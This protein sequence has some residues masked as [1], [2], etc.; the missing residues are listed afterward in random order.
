MVKKWLEGIIKYLQKLFIIK[1][2]SDMK[3][4][5]DNG[6]GEDTKGKCSPDKQLREYLYT[7]EIAEA[8]VNKLNKLG[9]EAERIV[10]EMNDVSLKERVNRVNKVCDSIGKDKVVFVSI[11]CN[12][13]SN[14]EWAKARGWSAYT[15]KGQTKS[16]ILAD[17]LY[18]E[19]EKQFVGQKI[20][21][22]KQDND[23]DWEENFYVIYNTKCAAVL[24]EN[25][26]MDN[27]DDMS[28]LLSDE[29]KQ[30]IIDTHVY[31]IINYIKTR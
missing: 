21:T 23:K 3:I 1:K 31:G 22:D 8:V 4:L 30:A 13:A 26:F 16:D 5:I 6:H 29:G 14:G 15:T 2:K 20:R 18:E 27:K 7:R 12:A 28:Y 24:T 9:Y 25:F 17:Y 19:A 11:H 10:T